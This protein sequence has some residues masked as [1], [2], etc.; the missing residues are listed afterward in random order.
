M[1]RMSKFPISNSIVS[2]DR[3]VEREEKLFR[4]VVHDPAGV[5]SVP[6]RIT[7]TK[8]KIEK[9]EVVE[10]EAAQCQVELHTP[11]SHLCV[12]AF[13]KIDRT[14]GCKKG[15]NRCFVLLLC[16]RSRRLSV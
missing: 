14:A 9:R 3:P 10:E 15:R 6:T 8:K 12:C 16:P 4:E 5:C 13:R 7:N 11:P 1:S 2:R